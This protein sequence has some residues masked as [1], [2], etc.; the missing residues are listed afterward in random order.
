MMTQL[1]LAAKGERAKTVVPVRDKRIG[2]ASSSSR[3]RAASK[4]KSN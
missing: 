3:G 4:A 1:K 2:T